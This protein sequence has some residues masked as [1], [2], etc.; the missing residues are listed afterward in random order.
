MRIYKSTNKNDAKIL[1]RKTADFDFKKF[2]PKEIRELI[3]K[4]RKAM[5][6]T[7]G[8][9]LAANQIGL[10][11]KI[12]VAQVDRKFYA[13]FN[14]KITKTEGETVL[15]EE[16]CL[17]VPRQY[18][19]VSRYE[20]VTLEGQDQKGKKIKIRAWGLLAHVFQHEYDHLQGVLYIDK[21]KETYTHPET[22]RLR[23]KVA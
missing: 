13:V 1:R 7:N 5:E 11:M 18:G 10:D 4:M 12:F 8:V 15:M 23:K 21:T 16:G 6:E 3:K 17:S 20:K 2:T 14:P 9:G 22:E 19:K